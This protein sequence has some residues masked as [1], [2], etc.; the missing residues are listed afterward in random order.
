LVLIIIDILSEAITTKSDN[1]MKNKYFTKRK[2]KYVITLI[3]LLLLSYVIYV[4]IIEPGSFRFPIF[5]IVGTAEIILA[6]LTSRLSGKLELLLF[7]VCIL[8][9]GLIGLSIQDMKPITMTWLI[10]FWALVLLYMI[11]FPTNSKTNPKIGAVQSAFDIRLPNYIP[12][13]FKESG[14]NK[15]F[16]KGFMI[17]EVTY[18]KEDSENIIWIKESNGPIPDIKPIRKIEKKEVEIKGTRVSFGQ[19]IINSSITRNQTNPVQYLEANWN[20]KGINFNF[21]SDG[22]S[23]DEAE[24]IIG[25]MD[26]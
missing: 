19:E 15:Y 24:K 10:Y 9:P 8:A 17:I 23:F 3:I 20:Y 7:M 26:K 14:M 6:L 2:N 5:W 1:K 13:S 18:E 11:G 25:S 4:L 21:R 12:P 22:L 16:N